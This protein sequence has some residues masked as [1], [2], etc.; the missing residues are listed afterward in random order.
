MQTPSPLVAAFTG[1]DPIAGQAALTQLVDLGAEGEAALFDPPLQFPRTIQASRRWLRYVA[2]REATVAGR[3]LE[4]MQDQR[5]HHDA[6]AAAFLFA[7]LADGQRVRDDLYRLIEPC[8]DANDLPTH[9]AY[10]DYE[11][12]WNL[13]TALGHA[14]GDASLLWRWVRASSYAWEKLRTAAF[15][16]ACAS[17]ARRRTDAVWAIESLV[18]HVWRDFGMAKIGDAG[19]PAPNEAITDGELENQAV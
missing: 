16:G 5:R 11:P 13:F 4:R 3:L 9:A 8:F 18:T 15:R 1:G 17:C 6:G 19:P 10:A 2:S 14:G 12:L 7:G